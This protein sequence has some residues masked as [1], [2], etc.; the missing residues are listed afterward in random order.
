MNGA[1]PERFVPWAAPGACSAI[2]RMQALARQVPGCWSAAGRKH[3]AIPGFRVN[4]AAPQYLAWPPGQAGRKQ[5]TG[6]PSLAGFHT[7]STACPMRKRSKSPSTRLVIIVG[8]SASV[9]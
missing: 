7:S 1:G 5:G 6:V 8:P 2:L 4:G 3:W 9:T